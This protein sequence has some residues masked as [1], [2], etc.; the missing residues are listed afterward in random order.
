MNLKYKRLASNTFLFAIANMGTKLLQFFLVPLYTYTLTKSQYGIMDLFLTTLNM[1]LPI[2][3]LSIADAVFRYTM[4]RNASHDILSNGF[5]ITTIGSVIVLLCI[6]IFKIMKIPYAG[7]FA[8]IL[9]LLL[10]L[11]LFQNY[12]RAA[13]YEKVFAL[14]GVINAIILGSLNVLLMVFLHLGIRGYVYSLLFANLCTVLYLFIATNAI[15]NLNVS[16]L[17]LFEMKKLLRYSVPL[18]PNA[19]AWWFTNDANRYFILFFVGATGNGLY[20]VASKIPSLL[21][22]VYNIFAQAWQISAV[23]EFNSEDS[24]KFYSNILNISIFILMIVSCILLTFIKPFI[25]FFMEHSYYS[26]WKF[27][28]YLLLAS[29][30]SNISAFLGTIFLAAKATNKIMTTTV[31]GMITNVVFNLILIPQ[32]GVN[33]AGIGS[34]LG[35]MIVCLIRINIVNKNYMKIRINKKNI[36]MLVLF[37]GIMLINFGISSLIYSTVLDILVVLIILLINLKNLKSIIFAIL[38]KEKTLK[39]K[40]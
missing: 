16:K 38:K 2:F 8:I 39:G 27:V 18:I 33:G 32:F 13:N 34:C 3:A 37:F 4:E 28:A 14:S 29:V 25:W 35:F 22:M 9:S 40:D 23:E 26:S 5:I 1:L 10:Y 6:P 15:N 31:I 30:F 24:S 12:A 17:S 21:N 19:F 11:S 7:Y 20:A 36:Y